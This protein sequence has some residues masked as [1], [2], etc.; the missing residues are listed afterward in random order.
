MLAKISGFSTG[1]ADMMV[2]IVGSTIPEFRDLPV[3]A[4]SLDIQEHRESH[5]EQRR[6]N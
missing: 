1:S 3:T 5:S 4:F 6:R 2:H